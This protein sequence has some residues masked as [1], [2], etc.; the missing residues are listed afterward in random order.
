MLCLDTIKIKVITSTLQRQTRAS[1]TNLF[2]LFLWG[3]SEC[4]YRLSLASATNLFFLIVW[5]Y[6]G[7]DYF[8]S[9]HVK[10]KSVSHRTWL[11]CHVK[12]GPTRCLLSA[13]P[14]VQLRSM[15]CEL[16][17]E[18]V[19]EFTRHH[20]SRLKIAQRRCG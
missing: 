10:K 15:L 4:D 14:H 9:Y 5:G 17:C 3:Y 1:A 11:P 6:S 20:V 2:F 13:D 12:Q 18:L 19:E 8:F 16:N 7:C